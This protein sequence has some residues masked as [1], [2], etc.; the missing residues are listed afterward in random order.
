MFNSSR[1][2]G[3]VRDLAILF[4][5]TA[6]ALGCFLFAAGTMPLTDPDEG[7]YAQ[8][9][10]E[11]ARSGDWLVP[12]LFG[13]PYL[14][15]PPLLYWLTAASFEVFGRGELAARL[16]P[17]IAGA[18]GVLVSGW[19]AARRF[20]PRAG[21]LSAVVLA[22]SILYFAL[23]R[24]VLADMLFAAGIAGAAVAFFEA[25]AGSIAAAVCFWVALA[26]SVLAKG[27]AGIMIVGT[28]VAVDAVLSR[29][30][31]ALLA[32]RLWLGAPIFLALAGP[33]FW[34][35]QQRHPEFLYFYFYKEHFARAG[36]AE[37]SE[38]L[39]FFVPILLAGLFPWTP[40]AISALPGWLRELGARSPEAAT[41]RFCV[42][43]ASVVFVLFSL[44]GGKLATY[45]LPMLP[46]VAI[47]L[48][49]SLDGILAAD[50]P[51]RGVERA[52]R[53]TGILFLVMAAG[54]AGVAL[55]FAIEVSA[56]Q[57]TLVAVP[58]LAGGISTI[59]WRQEP[60]ARPLTALVAAILGLYLALAA[61]A[62]RVTDVF[63]A[64][65]LI[66]RLGRELAPEDSYALAGAYFPSAAFYLDRPPLLVGVRPELRLGQSLS[67]GSPR[68]LPSL[69]ALHEATRHTRFF[70]L[71][72]ER[73]KRAKE[74]SDA[75][76]PLELLGRTVVSSL[77]L[78]PRVGDPAPNP[79][80]ERVGGE[81]K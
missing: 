37:H 65:P 32:P 71:S 60:F 27:P 20:G 23:A 21:R 55:Y 62:P 44:A 59:V 57:W 51:G 39:Y 53:A 67:G 72:D 50:A 52:L 14:E 15:K 49:R 33:W 35:V 48:G 28:I 30:F 31:A 74:L 66:S 43:W 47:L 45:I 64:Y 68:I 18:L 38:P 58:L 61:V 25:R 6:G 42:G 46:P 54:L 17:A 77:W 7:R 75:L 78:R 81:G 12:T 56:L 9:A 36:G 29:S 1:P 76:G 22:S 73:P 41:V 10:S 26:V 79:G 5:I 2:A 13:L 4:A 69:G 24:T 63:T 70:C 40:L 8:I 34:L 80:K 19:F 16:V 3:P 11:M